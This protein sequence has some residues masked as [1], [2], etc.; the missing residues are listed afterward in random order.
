MTIQ[1]FLLVLLCVWEPL[2][3][4][5]Q[6]ESRKLRRRYVGQVPCEVRGL[7]KGGARA[8]ALQFVSIRLW[9]LAVDTGCIAAPQASSAVSTVRAVTVQWPC[10]NRSRSRVLERGKHYLCLTRTLQLPKLKFLPL[11]CVGV[12]TREGMLQS[13]FQSLLL[14]PAIA[15]TEL[16]QRSTCKA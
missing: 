13:Q 11:G 9:R 4:L 14:T 15:A 1:H 16:P 2:E 6:D 12:K 5:Q 8:C 10:R 3:A 7:S